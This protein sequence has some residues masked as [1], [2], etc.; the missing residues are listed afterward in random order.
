MPQ[1]EATWEDLHTIQEHYPNHNLKGK[2]ELNGGG[3][4]VTCE[5]NA[6]RNNESAKHHDTSGEVELVGI[7][8]KWMVIRKYWKWEGEKEKN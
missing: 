4:V 3:N 1:S 5:H 7:Q 6:E 8:Y 2:V